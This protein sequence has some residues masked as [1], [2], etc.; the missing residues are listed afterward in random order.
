MARGD[1]RHTVTFQN[2]GP[3]VPDGDGGYTQSWVDL[4]PAD[5]RLD[6][7][8]DGAWRVSITPATA[9][10]LERVAAGSVISSASHLVRGDFHPDVTTKTRIVFDGRQFSITGKQNPDERNVT[11]ELLA[12]EVVP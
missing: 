8:G 6:G 12:V 7:L 2:P 3:A 5:P 11:M 10:D 1:Y 4:V 9:R